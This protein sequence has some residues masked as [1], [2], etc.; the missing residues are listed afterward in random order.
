[1][2]QQSNPG[3]YEYDTLRRR[4]CACVAV[5]L[6]AGALAT[7]SARAEEAMFECVVMPHSVL[8]LSSGV[9]GRL[10]TVD[11]D[12]AERITAGQVLAGLESHVEQ[13]T[14]RLASARAAMHSEV[15]LR[16]ARLEYDARRHERLDN[17]ALNRV[18]SAQD[19]DDAKRDAVL[20]GWQVRVAKDN[21][22]LAALEAERAAASL[23][24]R[25]VTSPFDGV[26]VE[27]FKSPGEY[28][29]EEPIL[30]VARLDP[31]RVEVIVPIEYHAVFHPGMKARVL[32]ETHPDDAWIAAVT[33]VDAVG[34]PAS[35]TFRARLELPNPEG[36]LLAGIKCTAA[37]ESGDPLQSPDGLV[38]HDPVVPL[39]YSPTID[40]E[41]AV[42]G[43]DLA[44]DSQAQAD[45]APDADAPAATGAETAVPGGD[46][47]ADSQAQADPAPD[48]DA[49]E[50]TGAETVVPGGDPAADSQV[51]ADRAPD[52]DAP[53]V[54]GAETAVPGGDLAADS[55]AQADP[56][57]DADAPA[58]VGAGHEE[59]LGVTGPAAALDSGVAPG[60]GSAGFPWPRLATD[61]SG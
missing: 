14:L 32:P 25:E 43:G 27:R 22:R 10:A 7:R 35:G 41:T 26:V 58:A 51:Q 39:W 54:T 18:A 44:A 16:E 1:M 45:P 60:P 20:A 57:L 29:D 12:R 53:A 15:N 3:F 34:D 2:R 11:V 50:V 55:Q 48:T 13:A 8:D 9:S 33:A 37:L 36:K 42:P 40:T 5:A 6:L 30:R 24:L 46:P 28:V 23:E 59:T 38:L 49:A 4:A 61:F 47:A 17:L 19:V 56:A 52:T 31:L 21:L